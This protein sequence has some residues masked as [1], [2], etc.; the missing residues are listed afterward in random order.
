MN[1]L[2]RRTPLKRKTKLATRKPLRGQKRPVARR[3]TP[4]RKATPMKRLKTLLWAECRRIIRARYVRHD[5]TWRCFTCDRHIEHPG[6]AHTAHFIP[7]AACGAFLRYDLR[8]LRVCCYNCNI[9]LGGNGSEYYRRM[10]AEMGQPHVDQ[11]FKDKAVIIKADR[12]FYE[13]KLQEY[14][15]L[16]SGRQ[17]AGH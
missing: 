14:R 2:K 5:G 6:D 17:D 12:M 13:Q 11:I 8:N 15:A 10:V 4:T 3:K 1:S 7:S 9:N 16:K